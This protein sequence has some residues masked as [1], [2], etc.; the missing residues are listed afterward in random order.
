MRRA[1]II[2]VWL[3]NA[4]KNC[5]AAERYYQGYLRQAQAL[6]NVEPGS[7][8]S[9]LEQGYA[10]GNLCDL[11][12]EGEHDLEI[13]R[14]ECEASLKFEQEALARSPEVV[15][16]LANRE[17]TTGIVHFAL[18]QYD[19]ALAD[20]RTEAGLLDPLLRANPRNVEYALRRSWADIGMAN[21]YLAT[22]RAAQAAK[23]Y[24][25]AL[26]GNA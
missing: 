16:A 13:A 3:R 24:A 19:Q 21:A 14:S 4:A 1:N 17:G 6:A 8:R 2:S 11:N 15:V 10:H 18:K 25:K 20:H 26:N 9:L 23:L 7:A 22:R 5:P 12:C